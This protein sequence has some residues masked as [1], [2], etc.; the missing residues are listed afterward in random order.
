MKAQQRSVM[1][2][3]NILVAI[4]ILILIAASN[5]QVRER[6]RQQQQQPATRPADPGRALLSVL[7]I[8]RQSQAYYGAVLEKRRPF[9]PFGVVY[10]SGLR[11][12]RTLVDE[13]NRLAVTVPKDKWQTASMAVPDDRAAALTKA[14]ELEVKTIVTYDRAL[15]QISDAGLRQIVARMRSDSAD[16]HMWFKNPDTCPRGGGRPGAEGA[17]ERT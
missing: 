17:R 15:G 2:K 5:G 16:H 4:A 3:Q 1:K 12:E 6:R 7:D 14:V 13:L 11:H 10:R 9:H 8:E